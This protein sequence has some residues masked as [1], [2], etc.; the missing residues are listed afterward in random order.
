MQL[1]GEDY[2][3]CVGCPRRA[4]R[5]RRTFQSIR[6]FRGLR[7]YENVEVGGVGTGLSRKE[8][9]E[10]AWS[11]LQDMN[12]LPKADTFGHSLSYGEEQAVAI[13]RAL[14]MRPKFLLLDEPA[15][16]LN[17]HETD[18]LAELVGPFAPRTVVE[19]HS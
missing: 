3:W 19:S 12:L 13:A 2:H 15:A 9:K 6:L 14:A 17:E 8:A 4:T 10:R 11:L 16:G 18:E 7:V 1:C 5:C